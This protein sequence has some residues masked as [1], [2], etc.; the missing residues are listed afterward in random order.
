MVTKLK[1][2]RKCSWILIFAVV[3]ICAAGMTASY[4]AFSGVLDM[5]YNQEEEQKLALEETAKYLTEG[6][7]FLYNEIEEV[8][9]QDQIMS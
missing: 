9:N 3:L 4:S 5:K 6:N 1:N 8:Y 2:S 7:Y